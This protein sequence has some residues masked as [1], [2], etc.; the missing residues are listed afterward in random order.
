MNRPRSQAQ[1]ARAKLKYTQ[2]RKRAKELKSQQW[3]LNKLITWPP[4]AIAI[5]VYVEGS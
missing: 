2:A 4:P 5:G 3:A 1:I